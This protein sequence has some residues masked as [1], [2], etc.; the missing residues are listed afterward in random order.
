MIFEGS[1]VELVTPFNDKNEVD[2]FELK[3]LIEFQIASGTRAIII[4]GLTGEGSSIS[5][6]EREKIIK[7]SVFVA[8]GLVPIIVGCISYSTEIS[9]QF[10]MQAKRLKADGAMVATPF[11][12]GDSQDG[13]IAHF[14]AITSASKF[15]II[16]ENLIAIT[17]EKILPETI[18]KLS[19]NKYIV[20]IKETNFNILQ[21][22]KLL[23]ILPASFAVYSGD[24]RLTLPA[25]C[26]GAKGVIS[27]IA[28]AYPSVIES[29]CR[30]IIKRDYYSAMRIF[31]DIYC[32]CDVLLTVNSPVYIKKYLNLLG[33]S[34][35][36]SR[37]PLLEVSREEYIKL[38][39]IKNDYEKI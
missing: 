30:S 36:K 26:M 39:K 28:N 25:M 38:Q 32:V 17:G 10:V 33:F 4:L 22:T 21:L 29:M 6:K 37:L 24:D 15:P 1:G 3:R 13:I 31:N 23:K 2:Y 35:G 34:V 11:Y 8:G 14:K 20:G 16:I 9:K 27:V 18:L 12:N 5:L 7:F 19:E